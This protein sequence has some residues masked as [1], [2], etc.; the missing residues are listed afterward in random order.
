MRWLRKISMV[1]PL[2][3]GGC[4]GTFASHSQEGADAV[5]RQASFD[6]ACPPEQVQV[7]PL[8]FRTYGASGCGR[9]ASYMAACG[10]IGCT[11]LVNGSPA[12]NAA[13]ESE[14]QQR[15]QQAQQQH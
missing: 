5:V 10:L 14:R 6:L 2:V 15:Q 4:A 9:H 7:V 12:M 8:N 13:L 11:A 3:L 1:A